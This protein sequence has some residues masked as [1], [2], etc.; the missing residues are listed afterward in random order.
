MHAER[1]LKEKRASG[2][3]G[4]TE[5]V[6]AK[7][8]LRKEKSTWQSMNSRALAARAASPP[9]CGS[10]RCSSNR[11]LIRLLLSSPS[12]SPDQHKPS[13]KQVQ[14]SNHRISKPQRQ[15]Q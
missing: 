4:A 11:R 10:A 8:E 13:A 14:Q 9:A 15:Q 6:H 7:R 3:A 5:P 1:D 12:A 2:R